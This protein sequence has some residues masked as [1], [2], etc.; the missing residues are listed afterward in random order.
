MP[1]PHGVYGS[2]GCTGA[3]AKS[4]P[5]AVSRGFLPAEQ[6][7]RACCTEKVRE[8]IAREFTIC[9]QGLLDDALFFSGRKD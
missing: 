8:R 2:P 4:E 5:H 3:E 6:I 7:A 1:E 9:Q